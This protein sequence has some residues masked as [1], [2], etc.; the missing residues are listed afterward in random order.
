[1]TTTAAAIARIIKKDI[2]FPTV[3]WGWDGIQVSKGAVTGTVFVDA[4]FPL[5][6]TARRRIAAV[7]EGLR[8]KG[9]EVRVGDNGITC[10]VAK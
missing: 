7:A 9:Y 3:P 8:A 10:I 1:M 6:A 2:G 5:E 4:N